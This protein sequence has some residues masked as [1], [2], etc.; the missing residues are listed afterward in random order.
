[1][2]W[3]LRIVVPNAAR[4]PLTRRRP[5][6]VYYYNTLTNESAW[7]KPRGFRGDA[8]RASAQPTP[9]ATERVAGT[10]WSQVTCDDGKKY[11]YNLRTLVRP[12]A[13]AARG[14]VVERAP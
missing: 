8:E 4:R 1:M 2:R 10:A 7:S 13:C 3:W 6:Q 12:A 9:V 11:Y 5:A 14:R